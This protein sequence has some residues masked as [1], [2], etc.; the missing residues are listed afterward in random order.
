[1]PRLSLRIAVAAV[2]LALIL[3][4]GQASAAV[5]LGPDLTPTPGGGVVAVGC[6]SAPSYNPCSYLNLRSTNPAVPVAASTSGVITKWR[7]RGGCCT[8]AQTVNHIFTLRTYQLGAQDGLSGYAYAVPQATGPS[9]VIPPGAQVLGDPPV[10]LS[11]RV[12]IA[13]GQ[14]IGL[15]ADHPISMVVYNPTADV[16]STVLFNGVV[17][18]GE[19]YG[20]PL[21]STAIAINADIEPDAD[22]D[23][24]GDESQDCFPA[25]PGQ[26]GGTC[27]AA[28]SLPPSLPSVYVPCAPGACAGGPSKAATFIQTPVQSGLT[29]DGGVIVNLKCPPDSIFPCL[30]IL[31][32]E[33][34]AGKKASTSAVKRLGELKYTIQPGRKK[35]LKLKFSKKNWNFLKKKRKRTVTVS[36]LPNGGQPV[37]TRVVLKFKKR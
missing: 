15:E 28:P 1:M 7:F 2:L 10:E 21:T 30:G 11:A 29:S 35:K 20:N 22:G 37:S 34:P 24:Y 6:Q 36:I 16:T 33:L 32:A 12:P 26:S 31:Y 27:T 19:M 23:G 25:D 9:F 3:S 4:T 18:N 13:A 5:R 17:Y 14:R 8:E